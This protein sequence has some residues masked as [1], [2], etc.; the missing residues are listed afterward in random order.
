MHNHVQYYLIV[1]PGWN[2]MNQMAFKWH[3][4]QSTKKGTNQP[5]QQ[6]LPHTYKSA[7]Y[8]SKFTKYTTKI[9]KLKHTS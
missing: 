7:K 9:H 2:L 8:T 3:T 6:T 4:G 1:E 5:K